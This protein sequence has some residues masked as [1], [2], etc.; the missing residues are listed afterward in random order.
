M[1]D[2]T[3]SERPW[4]QEPTNFIELPGDILE[5]KRVF[6]S[7]RRA[8]SADA[9][10]RLLRKMNTDHPELVVFLDEA[11]MVGGEE[12][13]ERLRKE[14]EKADIVFLL[15]GR[16]WQ[17]S[18][19]LARLHKTG[20][21]LRGEIAFAI[22]H[23]KPIIPILIGSAEMPGLNQLPEEIQAIAGY[24]AER[25]RIADFDEDWIRIIKSM[26]QKLT[27]QAIKTARAFRTLDEIA[28][29]KDPDAQAKALI[30]GLDKS[31]LRGYIPKR[32]VNG[33]G[34]PDKDISDG[35]WECHAVGP[36]QIFSLR[37]VIGSL[38]RNL[39]T[40]ELRTHDRKGRILEKHKLRGDCY[41]V[42]DPDAKL[43]LGWKLKFVQDE[44]TAGEL[45]IPFYE[46]IGDAIVGTDS[47]GVQFTSRNVEPRVL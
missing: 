2:L 36:E 30:E 15:L 29:M 7:Y 33:E 6:I 32:S 22:R 37:L 5:N 13:T 9:A 21:V 25:L 4:L 44:T 42:S 3:P 31:G 47:N 34:V 17:N 14:M 39:F 38:P 12:W 19:G 8:D 10:Q 23:E 11:A 46:K 28:E 1:D 20:D 27:G 16:Y 24:H 40:G 41:P 26:K 45:F 35:V 18:A 43:Q